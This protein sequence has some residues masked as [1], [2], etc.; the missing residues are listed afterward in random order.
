MQYKWEDIK[1]GDVI[2]V[3]ARNEQ[4]HPVFTGE[5]T[6]IR[7]YNRQTDTNLDPLVYY[8]SDDYYEFRLKIQRNY[9][10]KEYTLNSLFWRLI[11]IQKERKNNMETQEQQF[12]EGDTVLVISN[13]VKRSLGF[14]INEELTA[15]IAVYRDSRNLLIHSSQLE[16]LGLGHDG[17][18]SKRF[19]NRGCWWVDRKHLRLLEK[20]QE[21]D[22]F[23]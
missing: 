17:E 5:I 11:N 2:S 18:N 16:K 22:I 14:P 7:H 3:T 15:E 12:K 4:N 1:V 19:P 6:Q 8:I 10:F 20:A 9:G 13:D 21:F 23:M